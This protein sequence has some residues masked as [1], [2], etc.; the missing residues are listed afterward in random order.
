V[1]VPRLPITVVAD[2]INEWGSTPQAVSSRPWHGYPGPDSPFR[3]AF[4]QC[5][6]QHAHPVSDEDIAAA[7]DEVYPG[8]AAQS[9][10]DAASHLNGLV[11]TVGLAPRL[12]PASHGIEQA[13][14]V[15]DPRSRLV[16]ALL[17]SVIDH[18]AHTPEH[19]LGVCGSSDCADVFVDVSPRRNRSFCSTRCQTRERVRAHRRRHDA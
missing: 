13:W 8:F 18:L 15:T 6:D 5:W 7:V 10:G 2:L 4:D 12:E 11:A 17:A 16:A 1:A 9:A 14:T 3:R 19:R